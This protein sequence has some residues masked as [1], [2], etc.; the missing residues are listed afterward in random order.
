MWMHFIPS[1]VTSYPY[2]ASLAE[3]TPDP[4]PFPLAMPSRA[5]PRALIPPSRLYPVHGRTISSKKTTQGAP[6]WDIIRKVKNAVSIPVVANGGVETG[7]DAERLLEETGADAVMSSE[8]LLEN[9]GLFDRNWKP[10]EELQG[11]EVGPGAPRELLHVFS[12]LCWWSRL[13]VL[14]ARL[15]RERALG[16]SACIEDR[17]H[18]MRTDYPGRCCTVATPIGSCT[19]HERALVDGRFL[20]PHTHAVS[21][22]KVVYTS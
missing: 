10:M 3:T 17:T 13:S 19:G 1:F 20:S 2:L 22:K 4:P 18:S 21:V 8:G 6:N 11:V 15:M 12:S 14:W 5:P 9:P 7:A 16:D